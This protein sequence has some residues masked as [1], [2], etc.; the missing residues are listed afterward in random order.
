MTSTQFSGALV[1]DKP[2]GPTSHDVVARVRRALGEK[3]IGHTGTLDPLATGVL[4]LLV[5]RATRLA[6]FLTGDE[7]EY[8][9]DVRLGIATPTY[10]A[11]GLPFRLKA[12]ATDPA[13]N[14]RRKA[15]A[16]ESSRGFRLQP[17][18]LRPEDIDRA[19][20]SFRG[21][22]MQVP[23]PYSA[24]KVQGT[25]AY[26]HARRQSPVALG[27]VE[28]RVHELE[29]IPSD[30]PALVRLRLVTSSGFYVRSLAHDLG[31]RLGCG[32]H[33]EQLRRTRV[34]RFG[35]TDAVALD[36][37]ER[38]GPQA[39]DRLVSL[40]ALLDRMPAVTVSPEGAAL[41]AH[42]H[43]LSPRQLSSAIP[44]PETVTVRVLDQGGELLA[45]A[46]RRPDALLH[47]RLVLL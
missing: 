25:P 41:L 35:E 27:P 29:R 47:P 19:L 20:D 33:L 39:A 36:W 10:D 38:S 13:E 1:I 15:E 8:V 45:V 14:F 37:V 31:E 44:G 46:D 22:F 11:E 23:P 30:D 40:S 3:R 9:A 16:T 24:K 6:Q 17:E 43:P 21:T 18:E 32:A 28:V 34:G 7:K 42:G 12:E 5:G 26:R 2:S 4:V